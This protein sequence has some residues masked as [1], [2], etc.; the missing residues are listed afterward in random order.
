MGNN[1]SLIQFC[2]LRHV[3]NGLMAI[4]FTIDVV[5]PVRGVSLMIILFPTAIFLYHGE[6]PYSVVLLSRR[7]SSFTNFPSAKF[8]LEPSVTFRSLISSNLVF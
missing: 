7:S 1:P 3:P 2:P 8:P 4:F 6:V 5:L